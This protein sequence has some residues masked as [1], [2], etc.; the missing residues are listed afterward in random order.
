MKK[1]YPFFILILSGLFTPA[2]HAQRYMEEIFTDEQV[3]TTT[4]VHYASNAT[5]LAQL[6]QGASG[7]VKEPLFMDVYQP[8]PTS[9][10]EPVD[11]PAV[12]VIHGGDYLP[13]YANRVCWGDKSDWLSVTTAKKL[14]KMGYVVFVPNFRLGYNALATTP[15]EFL[16]GL[17]DAAIRA[18][19]DVRSLVRYLRMDVEER[20]NTYGIDAEK[21]VLWG[22][23]S[24]AGTVAFYA[25][26]I[27]D[28]SELATANYF[29]Q[30]E[31]GN[32]VN[33]Y[34]PDYFGDVNGTTL[35][36]ADNGDTTN[37]VNYPQYSSTSAMVV[38]G[39]TGALDTFLVQEGEAPLITFVNS[40]FVG[41]TVE[42]GPL[43]VPSTGEFCCTIFFGQTTARIADQLGLND[44]WKGLSF[45]NPIAN[46]SLE[47]PIHGTGKIEGFFG[48]PGMPTNPSPWIAWDQ[49]VCE[50]VD[51]Q[52]GTIASTNSPNQYPGAS[53]EKAT[54]ALNNLADYFAPRACITLNLGCER[55]LSTGTVLT[56]DLVEVSPNPSSDGFRFLSPT[57]QPMRQINLYDLSGRLVQTFEVNASIFHTRELA[58]ARGIYIAKIQLDRGILSK[59]LQVK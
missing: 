19:I 46:Q 10:T 39:G 20:G 9:A 36:V 12:I 13:A 55:V 51:A 22:P 50:A 2:L 33:V 4:D 37:Y 40:N 7:P 34:D 27:S 28:K 59:R 54:E 23:G 1:I 53:V 31:D 42:P 17:S 3:T 45:S 5:I 43:N 21:I 41:H 35:A 47:D 38:S 8:D 57:H 15:N 14:A 16:S 32:L 56:P 25:G 44:D 24:G 48:I 29:V 6:F 30:D 58:L 52:S 18:S 49:Q 26:Y 11:R